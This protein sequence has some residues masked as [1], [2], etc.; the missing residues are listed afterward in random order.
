M[1]TK[2]NKQSKV[3]IYKNIVAFITISSQQAY[4][5]VINKD[6]NKEKEKTFFTKT[7]ISQLLFSPL[8]EKYGYQVIEI[9]HDIVK[10]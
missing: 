1:Q 9:V 2:T 3:K 7:E 6:I 8:F 10:L 5:K 4:C